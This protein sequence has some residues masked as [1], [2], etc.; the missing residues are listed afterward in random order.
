MNQVLVC[1]KKNNGNIRLDVLDTKRKELVAIGN[2]LRIGD[3]KSIPRHVMRAKDA[4]ATY[5]NIERVVEFILGDGQLQRIVK[6]QEKNTKNDNH[7]E[8]VETNFVLKPEIENLKTYYTDKELIG[9]LNA[10]RGGDKQIIASCVKKAFDSGAT[11]RDIMNVLSE[12][13]GDER[14]LNSIIETLRLLQNEENDNHDYI[15]VVDDC[16]EE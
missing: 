10:V 13:V 3:L 11:S 5:E 16:R 15:S 4:G 6:E 7:F 9:L 1:L 2:A 12:I 8:K 14:L